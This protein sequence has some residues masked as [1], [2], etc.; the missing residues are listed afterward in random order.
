MIAY[1]LYTK[2]SPM[3]RE[4][5]QFSERLATFQVDSKLVEA[6]SP[7]GISLTENYDL[8]SRPALAL[9]SS[10]GSL[11]DRWQGQLP[12]AEDVSYLAHQ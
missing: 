12:L 1:L 3:E 11:I 5:K 2:D 4:S 9:V 7:E 10:D 8:T 6:D